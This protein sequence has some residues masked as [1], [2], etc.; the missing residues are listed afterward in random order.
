MAKGQM[1]LH[2]DSYRDES[3]KLNSGI[4]ALTLA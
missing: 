3:E 1:G 2:G 4:G